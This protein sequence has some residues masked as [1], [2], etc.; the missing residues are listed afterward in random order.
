MDA[1]LYASD[2][3]DAEWALLE[4]LLPRSHPAG[5][6]PTYPLRRIVDAI[7]YLRRTGAQWR[8]LPHEYP[9][10]CTV[11]YHYAQWRE[12]G[13]WEHVNQAL[14]ESYRR[15]IGRNPPPTAAIIDSQSV[16]T[17]E[18]GGPRG[19]DG[20]KKINGRKRHLLVDT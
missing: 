10:R 18:M 17:S 1:C 3:N 14:R 20:G 12:D 2:L 15:A 13:T 6:R 5:R 8:P 16:K 9:P 7:F 4:P 11:F 19:Y